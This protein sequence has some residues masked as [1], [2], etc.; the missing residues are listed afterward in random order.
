LQRRQAEAHRL[1]VEHKRISKEK[2]KSHESAL[3]KQ[4]E[5]CSFVIDPMSKLCHFLHLRI[6]II[7]LN[8]ERLEMI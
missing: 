2:L 5:V 4:I 3:L 6:L 7:S 1:K 8:L